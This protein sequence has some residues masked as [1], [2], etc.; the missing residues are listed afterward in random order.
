[1]D[2]LPRWNVSL[3][4]RVEVEVHG[5][6]E[7]YSSRDWFLQSFGMEQ[8]KDCANS[9]LV[10]NNLPPV[11]SFSEYKSDSDLNYHC[12]K[13]WVFKQNW[14]NASSFRL[15]IASKTL[16]GGLQIIQHENEVWAGTMAQPILQQ[17]LRYLF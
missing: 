12:T 16:L 5:R 17:L 2:A 11:V 15:Y 13:C 3:W 9:F 7:M 4:K 1:M 6:G 14:S 10:N 8:T